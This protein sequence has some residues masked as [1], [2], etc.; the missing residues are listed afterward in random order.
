MKF[1]ALEGYLQKHWPSIK[2]ALLGG[3]YRP[4]KI[5]GVSIPK[6][7][8][9]KRLLG[10]PTVVDRFIQQAVHQVLSRI[11]EVDFSEYCYGFRP[12][13]SAQDAL[14][15]AQQY[16]NEGY[17]EVIDLDLKSFFDRV[18]HDKLMGLIRKRVCD[19][20]LLRLIRHYLQSG[21]VINGKALARRQGTPQ[22]GPL[23]PLLSNILLNELDW[24]LARRGHRFV[25]YADDC[26]I[27]VKSKSSALRVKA[28]ITRFLNRRL[29]LEVN[30]EKTSICRPVDFKLLGHG[31]VP[32]YRKGEKGR[33][34]L[35]I[36]RG[37]WKR[38]KV[39]IKIITRK[40][41]PIPLVDRIK[42]L[43]ELMRGWVQYFKQA[44]GYQKLKDLDGWIRCRLRYCIWKQWKRPRRRYRAFVQLGVS[45]AWAWRYAY[46]RKGGWRLA[47]GPVMGTTVTEDRL[48]QR[49]Y[50][51]FLEYYLKIKYGKSV[52]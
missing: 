8:G 18:N 33:Y 19:P 46:S 29:L 15:K 23:S 44:T 41:S 4:A 39:K 12:N 28:S 6:P 2:E 51:S 45:P 34:R 50:I 24:E 52:H 37:S 5:K 49:G 40:T 16:I 32:T 21:I 43:N 48:R 35:N 27:F 36:S 14:A 7:K 20:Y 26:S 47:C 10:I 25:R 1:G 22:G 31:F 38:L 42:R 3:Q 17:Q 11:F 13:R 9:G 30:E